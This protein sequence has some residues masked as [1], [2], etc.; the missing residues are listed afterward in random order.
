M[1]VPEREHPMMWIRSIRASEKSALPTSSLAD[2]R[3]AAETP[4]ESTSLPPIL[5][6]IDRSNRKPTASSVQTDT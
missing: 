4:D 3:G 5:S 6:F 1:V 2:G